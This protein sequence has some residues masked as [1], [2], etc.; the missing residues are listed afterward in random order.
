[1]I[2]PAKD[3]TVLRLWQLKIGVSAESAFAGGGVRVAVRKAVEKAIVPD[4]QHHQLL[5]WIVAWDAAMKA[6]CGLDIA[7]V[8][9]DGAVRDAVGHGRYSLMEN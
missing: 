5:M 4:D 6:E 3:E 2:A 1:L 7:P 8:I 9:T